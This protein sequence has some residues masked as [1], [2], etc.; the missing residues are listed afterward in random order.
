MSVRLGFLETKK[1]VSN[2]A[3]HQDLTALGEHRCTY[4][5]VRLSYILFK[6]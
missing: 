1:S 5:P 4:V 6:N 2:V 3:K